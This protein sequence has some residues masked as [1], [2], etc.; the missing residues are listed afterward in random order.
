[1][2]KDILIFT[3][4]ATSVTRCWNKKLPKISE[5]CPKKF[6]LE[7]CFFEKAEI[8]TNYLF[9]VIVSNSICCQELSNIAQSGHTVFE[10]QKTLFLLI[11]SGFSIVYIF[12]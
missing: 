12:E 2:A 6:L 7:K 8:V 1:M 10:F 3:N 9:L 5:S 4:V 11:A